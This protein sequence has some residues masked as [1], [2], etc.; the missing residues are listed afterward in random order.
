MTYTSIP[1]HA[2]HING[3]SSNA[4]RLVSAEGDMPWQ[5]DERGR[6]RATEAN[7]LTAIRALGLSFRWNEFTGDGYVDGLEGYGPR[8]DD[9]AHDELYLLL[10]RHFGFKIPRED[11]RSMV[12]VE[13]RRNRFHPVKDYLSGLVW[14]G[15]ER[16]GEWLHAYA[17]AENTAYTRAVGRIM[18][19]AA[20]RRIFEPGCKFD[21]MPVFEGPEGLLK[22]TAIATLAGE[23]NFSDDAPF[24]LEP[25]QVI[26]A[27]RGRWIIE[28]AELDS[29]NKTEVTAMKAFLSRREDRAALKYERETTSLPRACVFWGTT[30]EDTY[31]QSKTGNRRFWPIAVTGFDIDALARDRDQLWAEAAWRHRKG[32]SIRLREDLWGAARDEQAKREV[33]DEWDGLIAD[34]LSGV[35]LSARFAA[36]P[37]RVR[38][39]DVAQGALDISAHA[40]DAR[41]EKRIAA[42]MKK[43]N[44]KMAQ[45]SNGNRWWMLQG[46]EALQGH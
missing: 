28:C 30:N 18:L 35:A 44:W 36:N 19:V 21:E 2:E 20:V 38:I 45:R 1:I 42:S 27:I 29:M 24:S 11:L 31:L 3:K 10:P 25:R 12:R 46:S 15:V 7:F 43:C 4:L 17:G 32:E 39:K 23:E 16:I 13:M 9:P 40:L 5:V 22:S 8:I 26:E 14:D 33:G 37:A 34:W 6:I 41:T